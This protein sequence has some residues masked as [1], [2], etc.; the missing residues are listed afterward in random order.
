[1][2]DDDSVVMPPPGRELDALVAEK[3]MGWRRMTWTEYNTLTQSCSNS[4][5]LTYAWHDA[6]GKMLDQVAETLK[7]VDEPDDLAWSPSTDIAA[8]WEVVER[9]TGSTKQW[10]YLEQCSVYA[11]AKFEVS[12]AGDEDGEW[13]AREFDVPHAICVAA[14][15]AVGESSFIQRRNAFL[16][17]EGL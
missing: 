16:L 11:D 12:G 4:E 3:V 2:A 7:G 13:S 5:R 9:L 6:S 10:F 8:A 15:K 14:L 1:M 17:S